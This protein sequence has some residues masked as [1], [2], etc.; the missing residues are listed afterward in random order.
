MTTYGDVRRYQSG[1]GKWAVAISVGDHGLVRF[2]LLEWREP[3]PD[4]PYEMKGYWLPTY[5]SGIY[6]NADE[7]LRDAADEV[8]WLKDVLRGGTPSL[9]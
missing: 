1:D 9:D 7:A 6:A 3:D 2:S 4:A 8:D 5:Q